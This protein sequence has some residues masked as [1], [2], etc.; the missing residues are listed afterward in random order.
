MEKTESLRKQLEKNN[1]TFS[2]QDFGPND[3]A[4][5][6]EIREI[7]DHPDIFDNLFDKSSLHDI[8]SIDNYFFYFFSIK[9]STWDETLIQ[10]YKDEY[11]NKLRLLKNKAEAKVNSIDYRQIIKYINCHYS[12]IFS[13][14]FDLYD[15]SDVT[16]E[17]IKNHKSGI[18][19]KVYSFLCK[20]HQ[21]LM[22]DGFGDLESI[23]EKC[24]ALF[25]ELF[26]SGNYETLQSLG[27]D[28]TLGIWSYIYKK[29]KS[30]LKIKIDQR[31]PDLHKD[32]KNLAETPTND[33][34]LHINRTIHIFYSFLKE[35]K[36]PNSYEFAELVKS[37]NALLSKYLEEHGKHFSFEVSVKDILQKWKNIDNWVLRLGSISHGYRNNNGKCEAISKLDFGPD[38][39][40]NIIDFVSSNNPTDDFFT[41]THQQKLDIVAQFGIGTMLG[42]IRE[43][44]TRKEYFLLIKSAIKH[45]STEL[46]NNY[47]ELVD[48]FEML[49]C[50][51]NQLFQNTGASPTIIQSLC[52]GPSMFLCAMSEKLLRLCYFHLVKNKMYVPVSKATLGK[53][54]DKDNK[55]MVDLF[56]LS[57]IMNLAYF[58]DHVKP[59]NIGLG[60]RNSLAHWADI[61]SSS[62][63]QEF[64]LELLWLFTDILNTIL[65]ST[66]ECE[67][68][69]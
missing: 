32:I 20:N 47:D 21:Y 52:Y 55:E 31:I 68:S 56:G 57:H 59:K 4:S 42:I 48:D 18:D 23:F 12:E 62:L 33:N 13:D 1:I 6:W 46:K 53:L 26:P 25:D 11:A 22:I 2:L 30:S 3:L 64:L 8:E 69:E 45:I 63:T 50:M 15:L 54:L 9:I 10:D 17:F 29:E 44:E 37:N 51:I 61:S 41:N 36:S 24:P 34:I 58:Y 5:H 60:Y 49:E 19:N 27:I 43:D 28:K 66:I 14:D 16:F 65:W 67:V 7:L 39:K 38:E 35:I 40:K